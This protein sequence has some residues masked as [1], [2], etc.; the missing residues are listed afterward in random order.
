MEYKQNNVKVSI[1]ENPFGHE[2]PVDC[3]FEEKLPAQVERS[4]EVSERVGKQER[5]S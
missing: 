1:V 4:C 2:S 5:K 3:P